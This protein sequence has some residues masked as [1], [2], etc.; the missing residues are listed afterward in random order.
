M[1]ITD[2]SLKLHFLKRFRSIETTK[3]PVKNVIPKLR[4]QILLV[5]GKDAWSGYCIAPNVQ[6]SPQNPKVM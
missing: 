3:L 5:T 2:Y 1:F 4:S 6:T